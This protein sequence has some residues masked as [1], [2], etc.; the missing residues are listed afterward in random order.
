M[1]QYFLDSSV[2]LDILAGNQR[3]VKAVKLVSN[4]ELVTNVICYCEVLNTAD[5]NRRIK[6]ESLLARFMVFPVSLAECDTA[7]RMQDSCRK[8]GEYVRTSDCLIAASAKNIGAILVTSDSDFERIE[9]LEKI[10][11]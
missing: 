7:C 5:M 10:V 11:L 3:S 2:I 8:R 9:G 6:A 1:V 4:A